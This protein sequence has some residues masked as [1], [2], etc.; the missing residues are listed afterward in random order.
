MLVFIPTAGSIKFRVMQKHLWFLTNFSQTLQSST[1][2]L[3]T[4]SIL[5]QCVTISRHIPDLIILKTNRVCVCVC[6][7]VCTDVPDVIQALLPIVESEGPVLTA[8]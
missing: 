7:C 8:G 5:I 3:I 6:V 4:A 2:G 1:S